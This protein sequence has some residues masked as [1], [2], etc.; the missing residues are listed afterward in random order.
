MTS[1]ELAAE[2]AASTVRAAQ[3]A[4]G[5]GGE[6]RRDRGGECR[7][8][9]GTPR[10]GVRR[11]RKP[12]TPRRTR[13]TPRR[14]AS[15]RP[16][17][18]LAAARRESRTGA[19]RRRRHRQAARA[20]AAREPGR[21]RGERPAGRARIDG[22]RGA[23]G[24]AGHRP[25][26]PLGQGP[27]R[28]G[29]VR[30]RSRRASGRRSCCAPTRS[31]PTAGEVERVDLVG[32]AVTEERIAHVGFAMPAG[33]DRSATSRRSRFAPRWPGRPL[34]SRRRREAG[35]PA[36]TACGELD[37]GA[38]RVQAGHG[39]HETLD[40]RS[41]VLVGLDAGDEVI[42]HSSRPLKEDAQ[43][44]VE[45]SLVRAAPV[46]N[47]AGRDILHGWG[48]FAFTGVGLG[49]LI[50]V[51]LSMAGIYR[52]MVEDAHGADRE[53]RRRPVGGAA[54]NARPLRRAVQPARR[55]PPSARRHARR[56]GGRK[57]DLPHDAGR[58][59]GRRR[60]A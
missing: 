2:R 37:E 26:E 23:G 45:D 36:A 50:G 46:I 43:V 7:A 35:R 17:P 30:R 15:T 34:D 29:A 8:L 51:T 14:P 56:G 55:R 52:G 33:G 58:P 9:R 5:G 28:P 39:R 6:P 54:G 40:G 31:A 25:G 47:L 18:Q 27:H 13:P 59:R 4:A 19:G 57:R 49:L 32:D 53:R 16:R 22:G 60:R 10:P 44:T 20:S 38:R 3:A 11:A 42:V 48:K 41:Q 21:R 1:G 12:P 24:P